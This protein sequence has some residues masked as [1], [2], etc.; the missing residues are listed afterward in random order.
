MRKSINPQ[1]PAV[2]QHVVYSNTKK[3]EKKQKGANLTSSKRRDHAPVP[4]IIRTKRIENCSVQWGCRISTQ[5]K[6]GVSR[7]QVPKKNASDKKIREKRKKEK[8]EKKKEKKKKKPKTGVS[9]N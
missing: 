6:I 3:K 5:S 4:N 1:L 9:C 2:E 8:K 7:D